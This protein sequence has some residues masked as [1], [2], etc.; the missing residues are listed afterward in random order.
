MSGQRIALTGPH[1]T[2]FKRERRHHRR[3]MLCLVLL[4]S[5]IAGLLMS[6]PFWASLYVCLVKGCT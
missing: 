2:R 1:E 6:A 3:T 4:L 5:T